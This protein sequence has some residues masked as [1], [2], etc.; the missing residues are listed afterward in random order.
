MGSVTMAFCK[1]LVCLASVG[2]VACIQPWTSTK[3]IQTI[4][5]DPSNSLQKIK[6][7]SLDNIQKLS[8]RQQRA[9]S[10]GIRA[11]NYQDFLQNRNQSP[12]QE[13]EGKLVRAGNSLYLVYEIRRIDS[14]P[15]YVPVL[16]VGK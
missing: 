13:K 2:L 10:D 1:I 14:T 15:V 5:K 16:T 4:Y 9:L 3:N 11:V 6:F 8:L 7:T 12:E